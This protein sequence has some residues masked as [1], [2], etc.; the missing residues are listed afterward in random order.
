MG[1]ARTGTGPRRSSAF[2]LA[3][4]MA[5]AVLG[6]Y[7]VARSR[8]ADKMKIDPVIA[9]QVAAA[10]AAE[11]KDTLLRCVPQQVLAKLKQSFPGANL[12]DLARFAIACKLEF[13][14]AKERF[15]K[16][17]EWRRAF[18]PQVVRGTPTL[19]IGR[20]HESIREDLL[21]ELSSGKMVIHGEDRQGRPLMIW[22]S[23]HGRLD[24]QHRYCAADGRLP[25]RGGRDGDG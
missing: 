22:D 6:D 12:R 11:T 3:A 15:S 19:E 1:V 2:L 9:K 14:R 24:L 4:S 10:V 18:L 20:M 5:A 25:A 13:G 17:M 8:G 16:H 21:A 7:S 23:G